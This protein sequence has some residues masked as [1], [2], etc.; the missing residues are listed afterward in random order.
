MMMKA[1][2]SSI[3]IDFHCILNFYLFLRSS[4][5]IF[6]YNMA[7]KRSASAQLTSDNWEQE[8]ENDEVVLLND[9]KIYNNFFYLIA[10]N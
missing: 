1:T 3:K 6:Q 10:A 2:F 7:A 8:D 9:A 5:R 4:P